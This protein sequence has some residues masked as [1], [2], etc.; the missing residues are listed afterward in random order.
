M[1]LA[2]LFAAALAG[3]NTQRKVMEARLDALQAQLKAI[4]TQSKAVDANLKATYMEVEVME[5]KMV[6]QEPKEI[7][8]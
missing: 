1:V 8:V 5:K 7:E 4:H 6:Q 3:M 2:T